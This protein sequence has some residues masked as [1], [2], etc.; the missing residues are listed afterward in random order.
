MNKL[1]NPFITIYEAAEILGVSTR[2]IARM[3]NDKQIP[4]VKIRRRWCINR[5]KFYEFIGL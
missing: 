3:C 5:A 4:A 2:T 1:D